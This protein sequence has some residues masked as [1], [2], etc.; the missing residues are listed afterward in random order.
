VLFAELTLFAPL[1]I[2]PRLVFV[3]E[4]LYAVQGPAFE[5]DSS[6]TLSMQLMVQG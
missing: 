3:W 2:F 1:R 6:L 4:V 5:R